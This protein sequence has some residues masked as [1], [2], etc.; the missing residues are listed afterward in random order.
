MPFIL[1]LHAEYG[2]LNAISAL[3]KHDTKRMP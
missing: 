1:D 3:A 2:D